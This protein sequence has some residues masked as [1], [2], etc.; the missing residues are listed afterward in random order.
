[1]S[2]NSWAKRVRCV[3]RFWKDCTGCMC[4]VYGGTVYIKPLLTMSRSQW[5]TRCREELQV[6]WCN[7][8]QP[9]DATDWSPS[10]LGV[11]DHH[12]CKLLL[13]LGQTRK[14]G[15]LRVP[16]LFDLLVLHG[17]ARQ[18][19]V[20]PH[21]LVARW[22]ASSW[23][24]SWCWRPRG[25]R[26][27][28]WCQ[29]RP[30]LGP[31]LSSLFRTDCRVIASVALT[32]NW[33][34]F[35]LSRSLRFGLLFLTSC[36]FSSG[37]LLSMLFISF[38]CAVLVHFLRSQSPV[39]LQVLRVDEILIFGVHVCAVLRGALVPPP[40]GHHSRCM[41]HCFQRV[42]RPTCRTSSLRSCTVVLLCRQSPWL[43]KSF[44]SRLLRI[45][46]LRLSWLLQP[47]LR[48]IW[49]GASRSE[50]SRRPVPSFTD[51]PV[52][53][54]RGGFPACLWQI[55]TLLPR[56]PDWQRPRVAS[57]KHY[58][59]KVPVRRVV[60]SSSTAHTAD[61]SRTFNRDSPPS[62]QSL[63]APCRKWLQQ[64]SIRWRCAEPPKRR[65]SPTSLDAC[66]CA[67]R[68]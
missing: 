41:R 2:C 12:G 5:V 14:D 13:R 49:L 63:C 9:S 30:P 26:S 29:Y 10:C 60:L 54:T 31:M 21:R 48:F 62:C 33:S 68:K 42:S 37:L 16:W 22:Q 51:R 67:S 27:S 50:G 43:I 65:Y 28:C 25:D 1:M 19:V 45:A 34:V 64:M 3:P 57:R 4:S 46:R 39:P 11:A 53:G 17:A 52:I 66:S 6:F 24:S 32:E 58:R 23:W 15:V 61:S 47:S 59:C 35:I 56:A 18:S 36:R 55:L 20:W 40:C 44:S 8:S 7:Q 38:P